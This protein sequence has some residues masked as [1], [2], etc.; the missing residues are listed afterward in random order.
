MGREI[1]MKNSVLAF[2]I[3]VS[4]GT[5]TG[6]ATIMGTDNHTMP[7]S[8]TPN[9]AR[10]IITDEKGV[11]IFQGNTPTTVTLKKS[12]GSYFGKKAYNVVISKAGYKSQTIPVT[13]SPS[14]WYLAGNAVLGGLIGWLIIDPFNGKMYNLSPENISTALS[15]SARSS[16]NNKTTDG[17]IMVML[18]EQV[19][20]QLREKMQLIN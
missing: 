14:G 13:S 9:G 11:E 7:I 12:D 19:P 5:L 16:H 20:A 3:A 15:T 8:S 17:S 1:T 2:A 4:I 6:C 10:V 18:I